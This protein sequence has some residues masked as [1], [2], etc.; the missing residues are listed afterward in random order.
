ML[1]IVKNGT[2]RGNENAYNRVGPGEILES[3]SVYYVTDLQSG[4][5]LDLLLEIIEYRYPLV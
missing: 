1:H 4:T 3:K 2:R 5:D